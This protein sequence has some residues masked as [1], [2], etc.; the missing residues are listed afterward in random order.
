MAFTVAAKAKPGKPVKVR[1]PVCGH[2]FAF[3]GTKGLKTAPVAGRDVNV[4][5]GG[6]KPA[7]GAQ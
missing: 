3:D 6:E 4:D 2:N 7:S 5:Y 1:C